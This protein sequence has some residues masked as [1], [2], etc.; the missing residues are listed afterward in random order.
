MYRNI[1]KIITRLVVEAL[2]KTPKRN[3]PK[4]SSKQPGTDIEHMKS[5]LGIGDS[6]DD[7][8]N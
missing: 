2:Q 1:L 3:V 5:F 7:T 4:T 8:S 6:D